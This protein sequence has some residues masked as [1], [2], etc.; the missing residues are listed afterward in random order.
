MQQSKDGILRAGRFMSSI[1]QVL[2][3]RHE[4]VVRDPRELAFGK[5]WS[6]KSGRVSF[7]AESR[8]S[9][10]QILEIVYNRTRYFNFYARKSRVR[11]YKACNW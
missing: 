8:L 7:R 6:L 11:L 5:A 10:E 2:Y 1:L 4:K 3:E 9:C